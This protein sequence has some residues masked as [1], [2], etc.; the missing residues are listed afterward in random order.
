M[1]DDDNVR[2]VPIN[3][4]N[5]DF[6]VKATNMQNELRDLEMTLR[7]L[8]INETGYLV[9]DPAKKALLN[10]EGWNVVKT[11]LSGVLN[12]N[13]YMSDVQAESVN[14]IVAETSYSLQDTLFFNRHKYGIKDDEKG[15]YELIITITENY[16]LLALARAIEGRERQTYHT[17]TSETTHRIYEG[18]QKPGGIKG[19]FQGLLPPPKNTRQY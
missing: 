3:L 1:G 12:K 11:T 4:M 19:F 10:E 15:V 18:N 8:K 16:L 7:G 14:N 13:T 17:M 5:A 6:F 9:A 2:A